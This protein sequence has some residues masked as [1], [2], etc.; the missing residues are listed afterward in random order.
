MWLTLA[1]KIPNNEEGE[2]VD[3]TNAA[4]GPWSS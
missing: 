4:P 1:S 3:H 2:H